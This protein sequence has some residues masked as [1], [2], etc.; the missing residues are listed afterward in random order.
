MNGLVLLTGATGFVGRQ[1]LRALGEQGRSV[2]LIARPDKAGSIKAGGHIESVVSTPNLFAENRE[3]WAKS[4]HDVDTI[5]HVAWYAEPGQ[6]LQSPKNLECLAGTLSL[7]SGAVHAGVRRYVG[8]GTCFEYELTGRPLS[9]TTPL[10][11][12]TPYSAAKAAAYF[13]V[14]EF[15]RSQNVSFA[16]CRL[17]YLHGEG[18]DP[19]RLV[20]HLRAKLS[21]GQPAELTSGAQVRD[22]MDVRDAGR[23]IAEVAIGGK[24][25]AFN[26]CSGVPITVRQLA[27]QIADQYGRRDLLRFGVRPDNLLDPPHV[28]GIKGQG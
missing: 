12:N 2:R 21:A 27:E 15:C 1:V 19:R 18:E 23:E 24:E 7:V 10:R 17:F 9:T 22:F 3:W 20:P 4:C 5:A 16:W 11:P 14:S 6:Y 13:A 28:V 26:I 8:V 25:G